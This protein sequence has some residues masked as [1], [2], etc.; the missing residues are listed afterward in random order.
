MTDQRLHA[1][2][3]RCNAVNRVDPARLNAAPTCGRCGTELLP[4]TPVELDDSSLQA[5]LA[6]NDLPVLVDFW[7][8]W[9][10]P[11]R[12]M[13]P[14]FAKAAGMLHPSV[15][16]AKLDTQANPAGG[17]ALGIRSIPTMVLFQGG[18][19]V[20]RLTGATDAQSIAGWVRG[21]MSRAA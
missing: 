3:P 19:E 2:C 9:C 21:R 17:S 13:A 11:C 12:A 7:A 6:N 15:R 5:F 1:S 14:E 8:P 16:L 18:R 10:G 4:Q 20:D